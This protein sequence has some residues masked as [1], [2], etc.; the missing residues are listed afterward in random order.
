MLLQQLIK[1]A[2]QYISLY[3]HFSSLLKNYKNDRWFILGEVYETI[4]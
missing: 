4:L 2:D 3:N 1:N